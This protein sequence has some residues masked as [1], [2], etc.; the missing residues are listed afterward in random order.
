[1]TMQK[2][3]EKFGVMKKACRWS[4]IEKQSGAWVAQSVMHLPLARVMITESQD[5][6]PQWDLCSAES[7]ILPLPLSNK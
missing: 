5:Q 6:A 1:M 4:K 7:L 2:K 3:K